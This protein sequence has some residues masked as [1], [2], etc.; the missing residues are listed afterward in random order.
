MRIGLA[1]VGRIGAFHAETLRDLSDV[2]EVVVA[3]LDADAARTVAE[4]LEVGLP[5]R[6]PSCSPRASTASSSRQRRRATRPCI[7]LGLEAGVPTFC[8]KP[9]AATLDETLDLAELVVADRHARPRRLPAPLRPRLP[10]RPAG[11]RRRRARLPAQHPGPDARPGAA[12]CRLHPDERR[13]LP[14]LLD[15]RLRHH[16]LRHRPRGRLGLRDRRQQGR[17]VL[18]R[19]RRRRHRRGRPDPRRRHA[20]ARCRPP[21]TTAPAT[22]CAW[23]SS[24]ARARSASA[25]TTRS[26]SP[27]PSPERPTRP[28]RDTGRSW[29]ASC[30]PTAPS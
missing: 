29:S 8:E 10:A 17:G 20:R 12:P 28:A 24:A 6:R 23:R 21:A 1:G 19:G 9:V 7:R 26:P 27:R 5:R 18:L 11:R 4:K 14:R 30:R 22:T 16:P 25:T 2:D 15:P 13:P 3:D